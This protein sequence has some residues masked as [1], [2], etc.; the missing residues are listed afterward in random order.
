MTV[1]IP[2]Q[3]DREIV[4][5]LHDTSIEDIDKS[6]GPFLAIATMHAAA[7]RDVVI[8][9][10]SVSKR[11]LEGTRSLARALSE[12]SGEAIVDISAPTFVE[13]AITVPRGAALYFSRGVD[14]F[15]SMIYY[16]DRLTHHIGIDW[17]DGEFAGPA[18]REVWEA[19]AAAA[20]EAGLP[21]IRATTN[22]REILDAVQPWNETHGIIFLS[23]GRLANRIVSELWISPAFGERV[24]PANSAVRS[25]LLDA[26]V[27]ENVAIR[28][29]EPAER[30]NDKAA[31]IAP[32]PVVQHWLKVCW[33]VP[34]EGNCG[35]CFKCLHTMSNFAATDSL[36][37]VQQRFRAPLTPAAVAAL[38]ISKANPITLVNLIEPIEDLPPS[39]LREA[40]ASVAARGG[41]QLFEARR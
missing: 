18:Q 22:V 1:S 5:R 32:H 7:S 20:A 14:S 39:S 30:R 17:I 6:A 8:F 25:D 2:D 11:T 34:G 38:D 27:S 33:E 10:G 13:P 23:L 16:R 26:C 37:Y 28:R 4:L 15:C 12:A 36:H 19:T 35:R 24:Q 21:L 41:F 3:P 40:W 29:A 31:M 9:D